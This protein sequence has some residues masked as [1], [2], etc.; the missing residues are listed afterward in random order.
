[1]GICEK[2]QGKFSK[3]GDSWS[4]QTLTIMVVLSK[5]VVGRLTEL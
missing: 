3:S 5:H 2:D 4:N 1:M